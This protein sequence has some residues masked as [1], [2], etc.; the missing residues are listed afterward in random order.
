[1][2]QLSAEVRTSR[3][4]P[5]AVA[6]PRRRDCTP[7]PGVVVVVC[8]LLLGG[9]ATAQIPADQ[10]PPARGLAGED[11]RRVAE[12]Q[13]KIGPLR[14]DGKV[15]EARAALQQ[16]LAIR[17]RAQPA[18]HW[19]IAN[20]EHLL[21]TLDRIAALPA[22]AQAELAAVKRRD[23]EV[24]GLYSQG[25]VGE[26]L[27][28]QEEV[29]EAYRRHLGGDDLEVIAAMNNLVRPLLRSQRQA[30][31]ERV[32]REAL[33]LSLR[34]LGEDHPLTAACRD[35]LGVVLDDQAEYAEAEPLFRQAL[36]ARRR[37]LGEAH[38]ATAH[39]YNNLAGILTY[40]GQYAE[41]EPLF[42][43][44]VALRRQLLGEAHPDTAR[45][46]NNLGQNLALQG[47][48]AEAE[49][50]LRRA[51]EIARARLGATHPEVMR[52]ESALAKILAD[53]GR[54]AEAEALARRA[55]ATRREKR[56]DDHPDTAHSYLALAANLQMQG[57]HAESEPFARRALEIFRERLGEA[58][59]DT[60]AG[61]MSLALVLHARGD[62]AA[63]E[64]LLRQVLED[65][66]ARLG[67]GHPDT[68]HVLYNLA[69]NLGNQG[70]F[71]EAEA[72][73]RRAVEVCRAALGEAHPW[74]ALARA[75]LAHLLH[76][77]GRHAEAA[78]AGRAAARGFEAARLRVSFAGLE[79]VPFAE[80]SPLPVLVACPARAG[81]GGEAW[82]FYE[83]NLARGL[84]DEVAARAARPLTA[85][86]RQR[87][88]E[89]NDRLDRLDR[90]L[91]VLSRPGADPAQ[92]DELRR[93]R[94]TLQSEFTRYE[95]DLSARYGVAAG[96][97]YD[98]AR[99]QQALPEDAAVV[100]WLDFPPKS[101]AADPRGDFWACVVRGSG[102]PA[103]VRLDGS[104]PG[105]AWTK[106][107]GRLAERVRAALARPPDGPHGEAAEL[108]R[109]L[110]AQRLAP[111]E[112][113]LRATEGLPPVRHLIVLPAA[114]TAAVP[115][116]VLTDRYT[117]SYAP[118]ATLFAWLRERRRAAPGPGT[119]TLLAV[120]DPAFGPA[121]VAVAARGEGAGPP[122]PPLPGT[123]REVEAIAG[124]FP[125]ADTLLGADASEQRL[126]E[127]AD[128]DGLR[129]Y[130]YV[131]LATHAVVDAERPLQSALVLAQDR[132]PDPLEQAA[133]GGRVSRGRLTAGDVLRRWKL[134]ADLVV[135]S[136]CDTG[137]GRY[138]GGEG[139]LGFAQPLFL[140]GARGLALSLWKVDDTA[141]ALLMRRF[142]EDLLGKRPGLAGPLPKAEALRE[143]QGWLRG[144]TADEA[145]R[146]A[147]G[148]PGGGRGTERAR[149]RGDRPAPARPFAHPHYWAAFVLAGDPD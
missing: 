36:E 99:V 95:A 77:Q 30:D 136:A 109:R 69:M 34:V 97:V 102:A 112:G 79:R 72:L 141:T 40:R 100:G 17:R 130:R 139:T 39:S 87:E 24:P 19:E 57:R 14:R 48:F 3:P 46:Y 107:D 7:G 66:R 2:R 118:S 29:L 94:D 92:A 144:L 106:D 119:A 125:Q 31:A 41:A 61:R 73:A 129:G 80:R 59:P 49:S 23:A 134:D 131:H 68:G 45:A 51:L 47:R 96:Q 89:L 4:L 132:L 145:R 120:G 67:E 60:A 147:D 133:A 124:L 64:P 90:R 115:V 83:A 103:W 42:R 137:L 58:H 11:A 22:E 1:M 8:V 33:R 54:F 128:A 43:K 98:L 85:A 32:A 35:A 104:G 148:L 122:F 70:R 15:A 53:Q 138:S 16:I 110:Y 108:V 6:A 121:G 116:G 149:P 146:L 117:V 9:T 18:G 12:L 82:A 142:Y 5:P 114:W 65:R 113:H 56:G 88:R 55:L 111:L 143:A 52:C 27:R 28:L 123:R 10:P 91:A 25:R 93:Q 86:D 127:L 71:V 20:D 78:E 140:A 126:S 81:Q 37:L 50:L 76:A 75:G 84:L 101:G 38:P 62:F 105:G 135:L 26:A 63:A 74:T 44:A 13:E 21:R